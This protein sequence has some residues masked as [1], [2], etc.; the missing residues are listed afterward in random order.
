MSENYYVDNLPKPKWFDGD[1]WWEDDGIDE[2][3]EEEEE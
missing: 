2:V 3:Y 1:D